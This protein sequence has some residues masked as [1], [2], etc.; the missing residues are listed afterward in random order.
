MKDTVERNV[1]RILGID[2]Y[3]A[4]DKYRIIVVQAHVCN[5]IIDSINGPEKHIPDFFLFCL[6]EE[7]HKNIRMDVVFNFMDGDD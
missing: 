1:P 5:I 7:F 6:E 2:A 3:I 4:W